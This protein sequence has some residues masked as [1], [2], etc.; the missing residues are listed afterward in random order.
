MFMAKKRSIILI[1]GSNFYFKLKSVGIEN[2]LDF[3]YSNFASY[4][5][6]KTTLVK[7]IYYVGAVKAR[8]SSKAREMHANQQKLF[9]NLRKHKFQYCLGYLLK[10]DGKFHEKGV[11][12]NIAVDILVA[13]YEK[14]CERIILVSSD[15]DLLPAIIKAK[16]KRMLIE[17]VGFS[18]KPSLAMIANCS[19]ST[20]LKKDDLE[21][22]LNG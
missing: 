16:Q 20:L 11:D 6:K 1:D 8:K 21:P 14:K 2:T 22:F 10:S 13:T 19:E 18:N 12:V 15:T 17:Y 9:A 4:L 5:S 3:N 7:A